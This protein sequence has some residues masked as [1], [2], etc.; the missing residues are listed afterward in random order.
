M[1]SRAGVRADAG[2][3][4][5]AAGTSKGPQGCRQPGA[6]GQRSAHSLRFAATAVLGVAAKAALLLPAFT[7]S[8]QTDTDAS[9]ASTERSV[10]PAACLPAHHPLWGSIASIP[11]GLHA[12]RPAGSLCDGGLLLQYGA[13]D[14]LLCCKGVHHLLLLLL[15]AWR[16]VVAATAEAGCG[17]VPGVLEGIASR[18]CCGVAHCLR[19]GAGARPV[20]H[21]SRHPSVR[22]RGPL[23]A[24]MLIGIWVQV[25]VLA[26]FLHGGSEAGLHRRDVAAAAAGTA[27]TKQ[28]ISS[29]ALH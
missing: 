4:G 19:Q 11:G 15:R 14:A 5:S 24:E 22:A 28:L 6:A 16:P 18:C 12:A 10:L 27:W 13:V 23:P 25:C 9:S 17:P 1:V 26:P 8:L 29:A 3:D 7:T 21:P 20:P 2:A